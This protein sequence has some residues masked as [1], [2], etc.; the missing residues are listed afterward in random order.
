MVQQQQ[1]PLPDR[2]RRVP[3]NLP[4]VQ[5]PVHAPNPKPPQRGP[6]QHLPTKQLHPQLRTP[7]A[8]VPELPLKVLPTTRL[9][10]RTVEH[11]G[12]ANGLFPGGVRGGAVWVCVHDEEVCEEV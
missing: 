4:P 7:V 1:P 6:Q 11:C 8:H 10:F 3:K 2:R 5:I 9:A 12:S